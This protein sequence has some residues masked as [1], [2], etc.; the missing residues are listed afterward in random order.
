MNKLPSDLTPTRDWRTRP[1]P[2]AEVW[3]EVEE[4]LQQAPR[5]QA[6][7]L[8]AWLQQKYPGR[9]QD[10]QLRTLQRRVK[11][12][13]ATCGPAKEVFFSQVHHPGRLCASDFTHMGSLQV[14]IA[15]QHFDHLVYHF[16]LTYSN[17][18]AVAV[19][20]SESF[21][22]LCD[23]LQQALW[24]LGGVPQ[25]HRSDR[26]SSVVNNLSDTKEFTQRYQGLMDYYGLVM[27]KT[28]AGKGNENG[29]A[30]ASH[31]H[32]KEAVDQ[33]LLLRGSR[34]FATRGD[35]ER[36]LQELVG[37]RN[38]GRQG[39]L[40]EELSQLQ[41]LPPRRM[42]SCRRVQVTVTSGSLIR[43]D[44]NTY[45]VN[46][47]LL[48]ERVEVRIYAEHLE[49]WY[50]QKLTERLPRLRGRYKHRIDYR[51]VIDTLVRKPGAFANYRY[52]ADLFPTS[53]FRMA[54]DALSDNTM[55]QRHRSQAGDSAVPQ[56]QRSTSG[57]NAMSQSGKDRSEADKEYLKILYLAA[58]ESESLVDDALRVLLAEERDISAAAIEEFMRRR[59]Q[60]P[61]ATEVSVAAVDLASFDELLSHKEVDD[62]QNIECQDAI[63][64]LS[65]R[66]AFTDDASAVR[67]PGSSGGAGDAVVRAV[68]VGAEPGGDGGTSS[69]PHRTSA[70][71]ESDTCGE[72]PQQLRPEASAGE[73]SPAIPN[74]V[75]R[76]FFGS[77]RERFG[78]WRHGFGEDTQFMCVGAGVDSLRGSQSADVHVQFAGSGITG[79]QTRSEVEQS[80]ETAQWLRCFDYRRHWLCAAKPGRNGGAVHTVGGALRARQ[81]AIDEQHPVF[82]LGEDLQRPND[83]GGRHRSVGAPQCDIGVEH[84]ELSHGAGEK[85]EESRTGTKGSLSP[86][87]Q[88]SEPGGAWKVGQAP[89]RSRRELTFAPFAPLRLPN[90]P[91][92]DRPNSNSQRQDK[93]GVL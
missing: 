73:G 32:F 78:I 93:N 42:Q 69:Q 56:K 66:T 64:R 8:F 75:G 92:R 1:D 82:G 91:L 28:N 80:V 63:D 53:R 14:T 81:C 50:G 67:G 13:R 76:K 25:R 89:L 88:A 90:F 84:P 3:A 46:S 24:Q 21:E 74:A 37:Q 51:H 7:T 57:D 65:E 86:L 33:A 83:D 10:S 87:P 62:G 43:V 52:R 38:V 79:C 34:D 40:Q 70:P 48:G 36:F 60:A 29:D 23:G 31:R 77:L 59:Q 35:Y 20:F 30:E 54:Y 44:Y 19:C 12:W 41:A 58:R 16:V 6:K 27:E 49:V 17:W 11:Q 47:R 18:E 39:R 61:P 2:F 68:F 72:E 9:F 4:Q 5:L 15:G 71:P 26:L 55:S 22:S 85:V 45:S